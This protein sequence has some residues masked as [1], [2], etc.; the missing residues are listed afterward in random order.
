VA[1]T[2]SNASEF[3]VDFVELEDRPELG[4][5]GAGSTGLEFDAL[6]GQAQRALSAD[7][8]AGLIP[9]ATSP[10]ASA[11]RLSISPILRHFVV[12]YQEQIQAL[13]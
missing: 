2:D 4:E 5:D 10:A 8:A 9:S 6:Q 11:A 12:T 13:E 7:L 1:A 3:S